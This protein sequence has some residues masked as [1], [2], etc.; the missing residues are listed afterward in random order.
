FGVLQQPPASPRDD[1]VLAD[2]GDDV[3]QHAACRVVVE[4]VVD[5]DEA[6]PGPGGEIGKPVEPPAVLALKGTGSGE[7]G[8]AGGEGGKLP[9]RR[10][11]G[12]EARLVELEDEQL[13]CGKLRQVRE[14]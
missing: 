9:E 4:H 6:H 7:P 12:L 13:A 11:A 8:A 2:A 3:L 14:A 5:G 10:L 1:D